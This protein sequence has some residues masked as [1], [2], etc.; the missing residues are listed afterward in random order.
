MNEELIFII[1]VFTGESPNNI[2]LSDTCRKIDINDCDNNDNA[3]GSC[4]LG[5][6]NSKT[7]NYVHEELDQWRDSCE[8]II[9]RNTTGV[10]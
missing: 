1:N 6:G 3:C 2:P 8:S 7:H 4:L 9:T 10:L 5:R